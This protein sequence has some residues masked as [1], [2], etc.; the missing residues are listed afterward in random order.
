MGNALSRVLR[1][2]N[3]EKMAVA[4]NNMC[5]C[6]DFLES[7]ILHCDDGDGSKKSRVEVEIFESKQRRAREY[8]D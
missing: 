4:Y 1:L 6:V 7:K 3:S 8:F 2:E 5:D